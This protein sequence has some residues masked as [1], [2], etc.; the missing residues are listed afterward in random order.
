MG[1]LAFARHRLLGHRHAARCLLVLFSPGFLGGDDGHASADLLDLHQYE[2]RADG[3]AHACEFYRNTA[4]F[5][6]SSPCSQTQVQI[7]P[8]PPQAS[9]GRM[10]TFMVVNIVARLPNFV[11]R[12]LYPYRRLRKGI[13]FRRSGITMDPK[14]A[15]LKVALTVRS[16]FPVTLTRVDFTMTWNYRDYFTQINETLS[17]QILKEATISFRKQLTTEEVAR[18]GEGTL[19]VAG[20]AEF[21]TNFAEFTKVI[22]LTTSRLKIAK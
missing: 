7:L 9:S 4:K 2:K 1:H 22:D 15:E 19:F 10:P 14:L 6:V 21:K 16:A 17:K 8:V 5:G 3:S 12:Q 13:V 11:L 18:V 20:D